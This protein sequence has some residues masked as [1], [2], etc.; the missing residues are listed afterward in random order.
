MAEAFDTAKYR[1]SQVEAFLERIPQGKPTV[2]EFGGKP[3]GDYH[4]SRVLPGYDPDVKADI[5]RTVHGE[6]DTRAP[7]GSVITM[8]VH[9]KDILARPD[10]RRPAA[11]I[12]GDYGITYGEEVFRLSEEARTRF[13]I[14]VAN[15]AITSTPAMLS[16]I[17]REYLSAFQQRLAHEFNTVRVLPEIDGYPHIPVMK[18]VGELTQAEA[19]T[20]P[21]ESELIISPGGGSG[22][23]SVAIT[24]M[25]HKLTANRNPHYIKFET[26]PVFHLPVDHPLNVAFKAATVDLGNEL[27]RLNN[28]ETNYDKDVG[29]FQLLKTLLAAFPDLETS[30]RA[31]NEP[32][33]MGV[34][35]IEKGII[36]AKA[37][38]EAC[39]SE[40][41]RRVERYLREASNGQED[42]DVASRA[43]K[44]LG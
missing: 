28:G 39:R 30:L 15:V 40:I 22:K 11:R 25:A 13:G 35:V 38:G 3:F 8:A 5:V 37:V 31:Y 41:R 33:D 9:A 34:N 27:V 32:T 1:D 21:D 17:G 16:D 12:R 14:D 43:S 10:G 18:V 19:I 6:L 44:L 42:D 2:I 26:F 23:F 24:E 20:S 7:D 36:D 29:N 4:A